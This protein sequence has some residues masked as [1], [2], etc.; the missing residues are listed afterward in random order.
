MAVKIDD[1]DLATCHCSPTE[2]LLLTLMRMLMRTLILIPIL[3]PILM[4]N[5]VGQ[6][7]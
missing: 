4:L 5:P 1:A 6:W 3:I 7:Q 2:L